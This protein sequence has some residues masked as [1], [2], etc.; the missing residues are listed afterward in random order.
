MIGYFPEP[1]PDELFYSLC[2]RFGARM[3]YPHKSAVMRELF[4]TEAA[5]AVVD[6]PSRLGFFTEALPPGHPLKT[7]DRLIAWLQRNDDEWLNAHL[8]PRRIPVRG[9]PEWILA[10][11]DWKERDAQ[12]ANQVREVVHHL[13]EAPG[14]PLQITIQTICREVGHFH[15]LRYELERM[16]LTAKVLAESVETHKVLAARQS[17]GQLSFI[18][19]RPSVLRIGGS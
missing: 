19:K 3:R 13:F 17:G 9:R 18:D 1:Y 6:L 16:P 7:V 14:R 11:V 8:P 2:A 15:S 10:Q 5:I 4:G 12:L